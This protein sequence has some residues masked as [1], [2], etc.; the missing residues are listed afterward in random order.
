[1]NEQPTNRRPIRPMR[2]LIVI[3]VGATTAILAYVI[4]RGTVAGMIAVFVVIGVA[5]RMWAHWYRT[6]RGLPR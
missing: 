3:A 1:M 4:G 5:Q 2:M 6:R